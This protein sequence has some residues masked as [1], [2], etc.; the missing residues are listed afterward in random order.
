MGLTP[1]QT[2]GRAKRVVIKRRKQKRNPRRLVESVP[3]DWERWDA[4][5]KRAGLNFAEFARRALNHLSAQLEFPFAKAE[6]R[7]VKGAVRS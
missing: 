3:A 1:P 2:T 7:Q 5:A 4:A 6:R